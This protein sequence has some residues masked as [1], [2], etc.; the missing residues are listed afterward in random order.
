MSLTDSQQFHIEELSIVT[1]AQKIDIS[2]VFKELNIYD[3]MFMPVMSGSV[4]ITDSLGLSSKLL[5]DGSE[6]LLVDMAKTKDSEVGRFKK[7]FRI[8]KQTD[9]T[10]NSERS[11]S[12]ILN[13]VSD[14]LIF[15]DQQRV[16]QAYR[17]SYMEMV[18]RIM[19]DYLKIPPNNLNGVYEVTSDRDWETK[20]NM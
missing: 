6:I 11:E 16:N 2:A 1:K 14:E 17:M 10:S 4:F 5:F 3:S 8:Y 20:L 19:I 15:S 12:Y 7:A 13:F 18:E 9:R